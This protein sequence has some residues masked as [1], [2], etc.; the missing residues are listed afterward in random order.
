MQYVRFGNTGINVSR[1]CLGAMEFPTAVE[2]SVA[3]GIID[4]AIDNGIN[5]IDTAD[6]YGR[7][8]SEEFLGRALKGGKRD[9]MVLATKFWVRMY[10]EPTG[11]GCSRYHVIRAVEASLRRLQT[12]H[13][14]LIQ[15]HHPDPNTPVE[16]LLSTL[17]ALVQQGKIRYLGVSN[18]YA[19]QMAHMLGVSA[20][21]NWEPIC[22]IQ[23]RYNII[24][25]A[26]EVETVPF[27][28]RFNIAMIP[29]GP[30]AGGVLTGKYER[31]KP[32][33]EGSRVARIR[34][35]QADMTDELFDLLDALRAIAEKYNIGM[36]QLAIAW[37]LSKPVVTSPILGGKR[38]EHFDPMYEVLD[39]EIEK[40]DLQH[41]DR[42]S[43]GHVYQPFANQPISQGPALALNRL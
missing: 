41:I 3:Q 26:V 33:P 40:D 20:L 31:G 32:F 9:R 28:Q 36:N 22:S 23:C 29:Y 8:K 2:E 5:F 35:M 10:D 30:L 11:G 43:A 7:G 38:P 25:R 21:H 4:K 1:L 16:E 34:G 14:D 27:C 39:I 37:L 42:L 15:L 17:D 12:D 18:H 6:G 24:D 13:I 19:W